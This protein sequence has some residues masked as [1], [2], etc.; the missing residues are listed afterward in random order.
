MKRFTSIIL[1]SSILAFAWS[2]CAAQADCTQGINYPP[3]PEMFVDKVAGNERI[4][5]FSSTIPSKY[6]ILV[7]K[8]GSQPLFYIFTRK[9]MDDLISKINNHLGIRVYFARYSPC[10]GTTLPASVASGTMILLFATE[11]ETSKPT[12]F[13]F[14]NNNDDMLYPVSA[15]CAHDWI[16]NFSTE[17]QPGLKTMLD[18]T[19]KENADATSPGGYSDTKSIFYTWK[20]I[21]EA[22][23]KEEKYQQSP[24]RGKNISAYKISLSTFGKDGSGSKPVYK[25]RLFIQFDYLVDAGQTKEVFYLEDQPDYDCRLDASLRTKGRSMKAFTPYDLKKMTR[26]QKRA[27]LILDNGQLCPTFCPIIEP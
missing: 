16:A 10:T 3:I 22:F 9:A 12:D 2:F 6:Q 15:Q 14:L 21:V 1:L 8:N 7:D 20:Q 4:F 26:A 13:Y 27:V 18:K 11:F 24:S 19:A 23:T 5:E 17:N 25:N